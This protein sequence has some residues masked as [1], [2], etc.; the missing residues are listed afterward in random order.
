[1]T[2]VAT[3]AKR[4]R[5][6]HGRHVGRHLDGDASNNKIENL[7]WGTQAENA[8]DALRHGTYRS[9]W[10]RTTKAT[11]RAVGRMLAK[12]Q[13]FDGDEPRAYVV[14]SDAAGIVER[15]EY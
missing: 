4:G 14:L 6:P 5:A 9:G 12:D 3:V 2:A 13:A 7:V 8:R 10:S 11:V 1:M 15:G